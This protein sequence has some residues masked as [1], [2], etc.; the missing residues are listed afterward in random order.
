MNKT[1]VSVLKRGLRHMG[2]ALLT[3]AMFAIAVAG[4]VVVAIAPGYLAVLLFLVSLVTMGMAFILLYAQ[5][6][7]PKAHTESQG[8]DE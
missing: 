8:D 3:A 6:L 2:I 4:L 7:P 5:G 1:E